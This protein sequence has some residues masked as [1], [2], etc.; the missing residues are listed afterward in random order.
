MHKKS[1]DGPKNSRPPDTV[2]SIEH[3]DLDMENLDEETEKEFMKQFQKH[4]VDSGVDIDYSRLLWEKVEAANNKYEE[5]NDILDEISL[6]IAKSKGPK[7]TEKQMID[8][9]Q[10]RVKVRNGSLEPKWILQR[11]KVELAERKMILSYY[12]NHSDPMLTH[13]ANNFY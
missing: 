6:Q 7:D 3:L 12:I 2:N 5:Q 4:L 8:K 13:I 1:A 9:N 10:C 11:Q